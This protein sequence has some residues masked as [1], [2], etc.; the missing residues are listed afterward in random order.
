MKIKSFLIFLFFVPSGFLFAEFIDEDEDIIANDAVIE[1]KSKGDDRK[2][3]N[4]IRQKK[5]QMKQWLKQLDSLKRS[6]KKENALLALT[7]KILNEDPDNIQ[8]LNTLGAFYLQG[9]KMPLAKII[10]TRALKKHPKNSSLH[11]NLAVI[12]LKEGKKEKAIEAFQKSLSYRYSNYASAANLG[13]LYMQAYE[14]DLALDHLSLAYSRAKQYLSLTHYEVVKTGNNYA[15]ALAW[16][17]DFRKSEGVL[18]ELVKNNPQAVELLLNYAIL[19]GRD[20]KDTDK[21][22]QFLRKADLMDQS[23][24]YARNIKA[25]KKYLKDGKTAFKKDLFFYL[26]RVRKQEVV[27]RKERHGNTLKGS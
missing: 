5:R 19:L 9:G 8:A 26:G 7:S 6:N 16:S 2:E 22:Y 4:R 27:F 18:S 1:E 21:A 25:L 17:G 24:R 23:G 11:N 3:A 10:F 14:Y 13:T 20:L 15:V 12:A